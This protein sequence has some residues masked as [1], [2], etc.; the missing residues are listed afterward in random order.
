MGQSI[1]RRHL[2]RIGAG[3]TLGLA[4]PRIARAQSSK[5]ITAV[6]HAPLRATDPIMTTAWTARNHGYMIYDTLFS[7]NSKFEIKPQMVEAW[8]VSADSLTYTFRLR[9]GLKFHDG[10][11]VTSSDVIPSLQRWARRDTM[12]QKLFEF[13]AELKAVDERT[14]RMV[15]KEPCGFVL[16]ALGKPTANVPFIVP[17]RIAATPADQ[18]ITD[19]LGSGPFR[20]VTS[21]FQPGSK[22]VYEK[23]PDYVSRDEPSD[24]T[25]GGKVVKIGRYEWI[26][27]PDFQT[28]TN[29]LVN[30]EIDYFEVPP[31]DH[32]PM[33][34]RASNVEFTDYNTLGFSGMCR[35]NWLVPPFDKPEIRQAVLHAVNQKDWLDTQI[36]NPEYYKIT[37]AIFV[38]GA[39]FESSVGW[40]TKADTARAKALL[41]E[42]GYKGE[43]ITILHATDAPI[44]TALGTVT[45]EALRSIGMNVNLQA[46]D[47]GSVVARRAKQQPPAEGGWSIYHS[48]W[49]CADLINPIGNACING[50]GKNGGFFGWVEDAELERLR[51]SFARSAAPSDQK[52]LADRIQARAYE[53]VTHV[54][55]GQY[56]QPAANRKALK[57]IVR[58]PVPLF[59]NVDKTG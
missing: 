7:T 2:F 24:G 30:D 25:G 11:A 46:M 37:P 1:D 49:A 45:A 50:R 4:M 35:M 47:W 38:A 22:A 23:N 26:S 31:H 21:E 6:M 13:V 12:G 51:D 14:F 9:P 54:P 55:T 41:K 28:A 44:I 10:T 40:S 5:T 15:L 52:G 19:H 27:I 57:N 16:A 17:A 56:N 3:A 18:A 34:K 53:V 8:E 42:G 29:A 33:I 43:P 36:G 20:F 32:H 39:P 58:A 59:W 48:T